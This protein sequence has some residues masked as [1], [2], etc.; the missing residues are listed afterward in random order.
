MAITAMRRIASGNVSHARSR[1]ERA[2]GD[3]GLALLVDSSEYGPQVHP[4]HRTVLGMTL[5]EDVTKL[6]AVANV[7]AASSAETALAQ[8][9]ELPGFAAVLTDGKS[10]YVLADDGGTLAGTT[11]TDG[12]SD[13]LAGLD[14]TVLHRG[15]IQSVLGIADDAATVGY[16]HDVAQALSDTRNGG[17]AIL[18]RTTPVDDVA[19]V[20]AAGLRMPRKSTL[21]TPKPASGLVMR[22]LAD[23]DGHGAWP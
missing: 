13:A 9:N 11:S 15:V 22:R 1:T 4:I 2:R 6:T 20:A 21:F 17:F 14:V 3:R 16:A 12:A 18:V 23:Q 5:D 19:A 7:R 8:V 10:H